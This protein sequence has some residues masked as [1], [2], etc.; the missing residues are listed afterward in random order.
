VDF[1]AG[2]GSNLCSRNVEFVSTED[3]LQVQR[4]TERSL[5]G[6]GDAVLEVILKVLARGSCCVQQV[7]AELDIRR[8]DPRIGLGL[9]KNFVGSSR[10]GLHH[11]LRGSGRVEKFFDPPGSISGRRHTLS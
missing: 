3:E 1:H 8:V 2:V 11:L 4:G 10:V 6:N 9:G 5:E 7:K